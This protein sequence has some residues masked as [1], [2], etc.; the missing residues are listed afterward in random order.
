MANTNDLDTS[1]NRYTVFATKIQPP[2]LRSPLVVRPRLLDRLKPLA[3]AKLNIISA[4][5]GF[6][7]TTLVGQAIQQLKWDAAWLS[8]DESDNHPVRF[9]FCILQALRV[10]RPILTF[11]SSDIPHIDA[12]RRFDR[13][14]AGF[15]SELDRSIS[16]LFLVL[17]DYHVISHT[18]I[19]DGLF[20]LLERLPQHFHIIVTTRVDPPF[21]LA[22]LRANRELIELNAEELRF[23]PDEAA[24][25]LHQT[26]ALEMKEA[27][28]D[29]FTRQTEG[30][31][32]GLQ[33]ASL[34]CR[35]V[36]EDV[37]KLRRF[38]GSQTFV[39]DYLTEEVMQHLSNETQRFLMQTS[40][41]ESLN[42]SLCDAVTGRQDS[43]QVLER[44]ERN[45]IFLIHLQGEPGWYRYYGLFAD[46]LVQRLEGL[47]REQVP[48]L[49][50]RAAEWYADHQQYERAVVHHLAVA[51]YTQAAD[52]LAAAAKT[53][54][55]RSEM[56]AARQ[57][58]RA[59]PGDQLKTRPTLLLLD[60]WVHL[61]SGQVEVAE[62][63]VQRVE[64][65]LDLP[66]DGTFQGDILTLRS[67]IARLRGEMLLAVQ[68]AQQAVTLLPP[69][70]AFRRGILHINLGYVHWTSGDLD[71]VDRIFKGI[72]SQASNE[73]ERLLNWIAHHNLARLQAVRGHLRQAGTI[74]RETLV[75]IEPASS[76]L[77]PIAGMTHLGLA[78]LDYQWNRLD[79]A[80]RH[81]RDGLRLGQGW[82]YVKCL[83][84]GYF[85]LSAIY[86]AQ[87][88]SLD[89]N[90]P[91][92]DVEGLIEQA[93]LMPMRR[94]WWAGKARIALIEPDL[95]QAE[96]W[97]QHLGLH[98]AAQPGYEE[99]FEYFTLVQLR[100]A[101]GRAGEIIPL[102]DH[103]IA[104]AERQG[105]VCSQIDGLAWSAVAWH[106]R[107]DPERALQMLYHALK[108]GQREGFM[109]V[110]LDKGERMAD[111]LRMAYGREKEQA[112]I[113]RLLKASSEPAL[114]QTQA[115]QLTHQFD[116]LT[117]REREIL[118]LLADGLTNE[119]IAARLFL[120]EATV[121]THNRSILRKLDARNRTEA[122]AKARQAGLLI[123]P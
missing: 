49:H 90:D 81:A 40:I 60:A 7:K 72:R 80:A 77:E 55:L 23:Q 96:Y 58:L 3:Q 24:A 11:P 68:Y 95:P 110:F 1:S 75:Q 9:W 109:R 121:K 38:N 120:S 59:L 46:F 84:S 114:P 83:L 74:Y 34:Y 69:E 78:E 79:S 8:L 22:R 15:L 103:L 104:L 20:R 73:D 52:F 94:R 101:Q 93:R 43:R 26:D 44:L 57:W 10:V 71:A 99:E 13:W 16:P 70:D 29:F 27:D 118:L 116:P 105:R 2:R 85:L 119:A 28:I 4:P 111:L 115:G 63:L 117:G 102:L 123:T 76:A 36:G 86:S 41:L 51:D 108:L 5:A 30:W 64:N 39:A 91:L 61:F 47:Q 89:P 37:R 122:V 50:R 88:S 53:L 12:P 66:A 97:L 67:E 82:I 18:P 100:I 107:R 21:P 56:V 92:D 45:N 19:H 31:A 113:E 98:T 6:G 87:Q 25:F 32:A 42:A 112:Y 48:E 54:L 33:M 65:N 17:D 106:T 35:E 62:Q 14:L